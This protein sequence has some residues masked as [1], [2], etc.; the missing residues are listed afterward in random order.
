[1]AKTLRKRFDLFTLAV[2]QKLVGTEILMA[3]GDS[4][5]VFDF[6]CDYAT[7]EIHIEFTDGSAGSFNL[8]DKFQVK[9]DETYTSV[10]PK[11]KG[12]TQKR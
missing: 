12:K 4:L 10:S 2:K 5:E 7:N 3:N 9:I 6:Y 1:M 8:I 11:K